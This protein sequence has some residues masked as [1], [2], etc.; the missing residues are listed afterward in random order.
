MED[1]PIPYAETISLRLLKVVFDLPLQPWQI[2]V[3]RGAVIAALPGES[4][5]FH[6]HTTDGFRYAYPLVQ[7]KTIGGKAAIICLGEGVEAIQHFFAAQQWSLDL[8][9]EQHQ[10]RI[11]E[12]VMKPYQLQVWNKTFQYQIR[13]WIALN[14]KSYKEYQA[15]KDEL[16]RKRYLETKLVG[17]ILSFAKGV[18][19][20][21]GHTINCHFHPSL[22]SNT[23]MVKGVRL[24]TFTGQFTSNVFLP[25][26]LGLGNKVSFGFGVVHQKSVSQHEAE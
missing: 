15:F 16:S 20:K 1:T 3:F 21:V 25:S 22:K 26:H 19:W 8:A 24:M 23:V 9:G 17:N 6:N 7:Y 5:L 18:G 11:A 13:Q 10:V 14:Q 12:M 2:T 4:P